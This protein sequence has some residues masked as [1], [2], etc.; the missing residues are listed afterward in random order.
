MPIVFQ[1]GSISSLVLEFEYDTVGFWISENR[2][3]RLKLCPDLALIP[4]RSGQSVDSE[5][6][7]HH[8]EQLHVR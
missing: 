4:L 1:A 5:E 2:C 8:D 6:V 3:P 7:G